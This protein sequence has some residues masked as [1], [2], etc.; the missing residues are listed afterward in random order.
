MIRRSVLAALVLCAPV[1]AMAQHGGGPPGGGG[2]GGG[3]MGG[4]NMGGMGMGRGINGG[5]MNR[6][7]MGGS[8]FVAVSPMHSGLQLGLPG[9]WWDEKKM[10]KSL[11]LRN[12]QK[13]RM[14]EIFNSSEGNLSTLLTNLQR[15]EVHLSTLSSADLQD[16]TKVFAAIDRY[17][18]ARTELAKEKAHVLMQIRQQLDPDQLNKLDTEIAS[19]R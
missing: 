9:R 12:D 3:A 16:E 13:S 14:D 1:A 6:P 2:M 15:E 4:G 17:E 8:H 19:L 10:V 5:T 11:S 18:A 7:P